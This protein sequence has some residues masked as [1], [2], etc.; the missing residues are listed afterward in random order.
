MYEPAPPVQAKNDSSDGL[1]KDAFM[2]SAYKWGNTLSPAP[3][4][5]AILIANHFCG[6]L[7]RPE[8]LKLYEIRSYLFH[9]L[10]HSRFSPKTSKLF[11]LRL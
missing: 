9:H 2:Y 6:V 5:S 4:V 10:S 11:T 1:G 8:K 7:W 3:M